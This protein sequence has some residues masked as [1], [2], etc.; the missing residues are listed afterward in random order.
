MLA[1]ALCAAPAGAR[2]D[3]IS[4]QAEG[5]YSNS[6]TTTDSAGQRTKTDADA[7]TQ[8]YRLGVEETIYPQL[9][10]QANGLL[11]WV[12]GSS[13]T[14]GLRTD[15]DQKTWDGNAHLVWGSPVVFGGLDWDR[16]E[17]T[18]ESRTAGVATTAP[19][20]VRDVYAGSVGW[21]PLDLPTLD[22]RVSRTNSY[23]T[24]HR[25]MDLTTD[26][27]LLVSRF[28]PLPSLDVRYSARYAT[29]TDHL[30]GV[31]TT[32]FTNTGT[33]TWTD[34]FL[35]DRGNAYVSYGI[36]TQNNQTSTR[37]AFGTVQTQRFPVA[38]LSLVEGPL[39]VPAQVTLTPNAALIDG[40]LT[41]SAG[42]NLGFNASAGPVVTNRDLGAQ[43]PN[44]VTR[45]SLIYVYVDKNVAPV[46]SQL[47]WTAYQSQDNV[48]WQQVGLA[49]IVDFDPLQFRF[50]IPILP[51]TA[52]YLKVVTKPI[53]R[54]LTTDPQ[55]ADIF[56]TELQLFDVALASDL[57][58]RSFNLS[59]TLNGTS[60]LM[61]VRS[62]S[63]AYD[64]SAILTHS[65]VEPNGTY[66]VVNGLSAQRRV[67]TG[68]TASARVDRS[69]TDAGRGHE[70]LNR[71]SGTLTF[72]PLPTLG[73]TLAYS[74]QFAQRLAGNAISHTGTAFARADLYEGISS[75]ATGSVG[76]TNDE[77]G[78]T[79]RSENGT[80]SLSLVPNR[81]VTTTGSASIT[82]AVQT[83]GGRPDLTDRR[84]VLELTASVSPF[85]ALS[86]A[87][88]V[89]RFFGTTGTSTLVNFN[90]ALSLFP[91]G[92]LQLS[93]NYQ[94]S[95]DTGAQSRTRTH[96]PGLRWNIRR[97]W[98]LTSGYTFQH[99]AD[100]SQ[101]TNGQAVNADLIIVFH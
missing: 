59:G 58:G 63:L 79:T 87:G 99:T 37:S 75:S 57:R 5:A 62:A 81:I 56:V 91:G 33:V 3:G 41:G 100:P 65:N 95:L 61:L 55:F 12:N 76:W 52:R 16:R 10:F 39:D 97:G 92:D 68:V 43:L 6:T 70:G 83:G 13:R 93:Y 78:R 71:W 94:E 14:N 80:L 74:G 44:D 47:A 19:G 23:D 34:K 67:A 29:L 50:S 25:S 24:A 82:N 45:V 54:Q 53:V 1:A 35:E 38:G 60:R 27:A 90:G 20:L 64:F 51:T 11:D 17:Q 101:T 46:A 30:G 4:G 88:S 98:Y 96:G 84:G 8:R 49:G 73:G 9:K 72:D 42:I 85:R 7:W 86:L 22:L 32:S 40:V 2:A 36:V 69:D 28:D 31:E 48:T 89:V 15:F 66:A 21:H 77:T 26:E 18:S